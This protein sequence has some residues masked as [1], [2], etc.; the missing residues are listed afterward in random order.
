MPDHYQ[1]FKRDGDDASLPMRECTLIA[2]RNTVVHGLVDARLPPYL[3]AQER[4][5][6]L[7][8]PVT[9]CRCKFH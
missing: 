1:Q 2:N 9:P 3:P 5:G 4:D 8:P 6:K 7:Q